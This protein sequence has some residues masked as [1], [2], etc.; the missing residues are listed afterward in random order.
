MDADRYARIQALF[1]AALEYPLAE[2]LGFIVQASGDDADLRAAVERLLAADDEAFD[3]LDVPLGDVHRLDGA[4]TTV[5]PPLPSQVGAYQIE[6]LLGAGGMGTVYRARRTDVD[7][8][9][10]LKLV[11]GALARPERIHRFLQER[12][13]LARL[14]HPHIAALLDAGQTDDGT[15]FFAMEYVD[16]LALTAYGERHQ[17]SVQERLDLFTAVGDAVQHAHRHFIVHRDLKPSNILVTE[18]GGGRPLVKLLDFGI[19]KLVDEADG[20][21]GLTQTGHHLLTPAYAAPEQLTGGPITTTTDVYSLGVVLYELLTGQRPFAVETLAEAH[22]VLQTAPTPPSKAVSSD[23]AT[24][25]YGGGTMEHVSRRLRGDLDQICLKALAHEPARRYPSAEAFVA[26]IRRHLAGLPV[27]AQ[28]DTLGYRIRKFVQRHRVPVAAGAAVVLV[29]VASLA[30][31]LWQARQV[32]QERDLA[33]QETAKVEEIAS[34]LTDLFMASD[35]WSAVRTDTLRALDLL[36]QGAERVRT[37][38]TGQPAVQA[39]LLRRIGEVYRVRDERETARTLLNEALALERGLSAETGPLSAGLALALFELGK[40]DENDDFAAADSAF[41]EALAIQERLYG[42]SHPDVATTLKGIASTRYYAGDLEAAVTLAREAAAIHEQSLGATHP[43]TLASLNDLGV[44]L[45][46][47]GEVEEAVRV[48]QASL[49][50]A[51]AHWGA[52][53]PEVATTQQ[54][55]SVVLARLGRLREAEWLVRSSLQI[56][57]ARLPEGHPLITTSLN[58][59]GNVLRQQ[60]Q[61]EEAV[62]TLRDAVRLAELNNEGPLDVATKLNNLGLALS[63]QG[64]YD[65]AV[66]LYERS[67]ALRIDALGPDHPRVTIQRYNLAALLHE[68]GDFEAAVTGFRDV[69]ARDSAALG[70]DHH[71]VAVD[72]MKLGASLVD[73]GQY[74]VAAWHLEASLAILRATMPA[75]HPRIAEARLAQGRLAL[76]RGVASE[77]QVA[78]EEAVAIRRAVY[79][80]AHPRIAEARVYLGLALQQQGALDEANAHLSEALPVLD[81]T[82]GALARAAAAGQQGWASADR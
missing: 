82:Q 45:S 21:A 73:L 62:R 71:E 6:G 50:G 4:E 54:A 64:V 36:A 63:I 77:A 3:L 16:G 49:T 32:A 29:L 1:E 76:A 43:R 78:L 33:Q 75:E 53:H 59:L 8:V 81:G 20:Q 52:D 18:D 55:L 39:E 61:Y 23:T 22:Q 74:D 68:Q 40:L 34:F 17:L 31:S 26:D 2:R 5:P 69:V 58:T 25:T 27:E 10:A 80:P 44:F 47:A 66:G 11:R 19:A 13:V 9:V 38:L 30:S 7:K 57:Q 67:L 28:P 72:R 46:R 41:R 48:L 65:E 60:G 51:E 79:E 37:D 35:P 15:P 56:R 14:T 12:D 42:R 24:G 70:A